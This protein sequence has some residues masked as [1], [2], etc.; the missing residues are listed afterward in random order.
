MLSIERL[1]ENVYHSRYLLCFDVDWFYFNRG[2]V[3]AKTSNFTHSF[4]IVG[5]ALWLDEYIQYVEDILDMVT[6][7]QDRQHTR[8]MVILIHQVTNMHNIADH[9]EFILDKCELIVDK[10]M[11][12]FPRR[13]FPISGWQE[14]G[15]LRCPFEFRLI[16]PSFYKNFDDAVQRFVAKKGRRDLGWA[17]CAWLSKR[18]REHERNIDRLLLFDLINILDQMGFRG[19]SLDSA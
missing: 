3:Q 10:G 19:I 15:G 13:R 11:D 2:R 14:C 1:I 12:W 8:E 4:D 9:F 16:F 17:G 6:V 5:T 18:E 7:Y